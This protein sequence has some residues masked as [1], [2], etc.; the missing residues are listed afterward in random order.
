VSGYYESP[1]RLDE[2]ATAL[3][4]CRGG[5]ERARS[6]AD[7][8]AAA[9]AA[10]L[11]EV[12]GGAVSTP[13]MG[14]VR[15]DVLRELEEQRVWLDKVRAQLASTTVPADYRQTTLPALRGMEDSLATTER[16]VAGAT[17]SVSGSFA[18]F[19]RAVGADERLVAARTALG[20][21]L[22]ELQTSG[23]TLREW[24]PDRYAALTDRLSR[25]RTEAAELVAGG[26]LAAIAEGA[27]RLA[28]ET[29]SLT[30]AVKEAAEAAEARRAAIQRRDYL[31][32][33]LVAVCEDLGFERMDAPTVA[34]ADVVSIRFDTVDR[35][36]IDFRLGLDGRIVTDSAIDP[37]YCAE[38][39]D[40]LGDAL[41]A[42]Y[43][44]GTQFTALQHDDERPTSR[45]FEAAEEPTS[46]TQ[47]LPGPE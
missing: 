40:Q 11:A 32:A 37:S 45:T 2:R 15:L 33:S 10:V 1:V 25:A 5:L 9:L 46:D 13:E 41:A 27:E 3:V 18:R 43:G 21:T 35:G 22:Q 20:Q 26:D 42:E 39:F 34:E 31:A 7:A 12:A 36:I 23:V 38:Q 24:M 8:L 17:S 28:A 4:T 47:A 6:A 16:H 19:Q 30:A 44:L 14:Q 29:T